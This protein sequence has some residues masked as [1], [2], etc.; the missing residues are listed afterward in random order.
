MILGLDLSAKE[1]NRTGYFY[2]N[3]KPIF[4]IL[5]K[6]EK[7]LNLIENE[8][9]KYIFIDAPLSYEYPYRI[10]EK[11]L[12][13]YGFK[14]LPLSLKSMKLLYERA[15]L[16]KS[17]II[18]INKDIEVYETFP[19]AVEKILK[20]KYQYF[21]KVFKYKDI[22]DAYLS[23]LSGLFFKLNRYQKFGNLILPKI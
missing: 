13:K 2:F 11:L 12:Y 7:I 16:L 18:E 14:P 20:L 1:N 21:S 8:K 9:F 6:N 17:K 5:N 19:R 22:Y 4:G 3:K 10:E 15:N 23:Y